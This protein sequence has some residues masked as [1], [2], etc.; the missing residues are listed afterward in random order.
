MKQLALVCCIVLQGG[1]AAFSQNS[2][3]PAPE[4]LYMVAATPAQGYPIT[5]YKTGEKNKLAPVRTIVASDGDVTVTPSDDA[6]FFTD[7]SEKPT[8]VTVLHFTDPL[9]DDQVPVNPGELVSELSLMMTAKPGSGREQFLLPLIELGKNGSLSK[10]PLVSV[11][12]NADGAQQRVQPGNWEVYQSLRFEGV[13]GGPSINWL[14]EARVIGGQIVLSR[15]GRIEQHHVPLAAPPEALSQL[16]PET[17]PLAILASS[18]NYLV[19]CRLTLN[20]SHDAESV[21]TPFILYVLH[22]RTGRWQTIQAEGFA[23]VRL[24]GP[25]LTVDVTMPNPER[26]PGPG[27]D[28]ERS[29]DSDRL[30][31]VQGAYD[32]LQGFQYRPGILDLYN[33]EDG[34]TLQIKT[35]QEDSEVLGVRNGAV[36]YRA[37][38]SIYRAALTGHTL[39]EPALVAHD[40]DVPEIHWLFWSN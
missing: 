2:S 37:G 12:V 38:D 25:W 30:P 10:Q 9:R 34:A 14:P 7:P 22:R 3:A 4:Q 8:R 39:G 29:S 33:L 21:A 16:N 26:K 1:P 24:L 23:G 35:G 18:D 6:L 27:R 11:S 19:V 20:S 40:E 13:P 5:V 17:D 31:S 15:F 32:F 36:L 28:K